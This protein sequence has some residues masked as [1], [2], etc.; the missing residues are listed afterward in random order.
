MPLKNAIQSAQRR[1]RRIPVPIN[2]DAGSPALGIVT[3]EVT[4]TRQ[5]VGDY[6]LTFREPYVIAPYAQITGLEDNAVGRVGA[7]TV[8][9]IQI[10]IEDASSNAAADLDVIV[11]VIGWD[12]EDLV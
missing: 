8:S 1:E 10:L 11:D 9:S 3:N 4:L 6:L 12:G 2:A 7:R 5:G